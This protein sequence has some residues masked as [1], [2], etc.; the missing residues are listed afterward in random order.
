MTT[1]EPATALIRAVGVVVPAR[2]EQSRVGDCLRALRAALD[3]I[4][5]E[6][7]RAVC[8]IVDRCQDDTASVVRSVLE[9]RPWHHIEIVENRRGLTIGGLRALGMRQLLRA[10]DPIPQARTWLLSTDADS[11]VPPNWV[12]DHLHH[13]DAG[14]DAVA[15]AVTLDEPD[16]LDP[17]ALRRYTEIVDAGT[18]GPTHSHV[19]AANLGVRASAYT[20]VGG[21]PAV[22]S[23]E[24][25]LLLRRLRSAGHPVVTSTRLRVRT[26]ARVQGRT[27]AGLA[28]LL[29]QLHPNAS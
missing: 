10:L 27:G 11:T 16:R 1:P 15:G 23:G 26:S 14:A 2:D 4:S 17:V 5:G 19:Y 22:G 9:E 21:F 12:V 18:T 13:A 24:E 8:V 3:E 7:L 25:H 29:G 28:E 20:G 6:L